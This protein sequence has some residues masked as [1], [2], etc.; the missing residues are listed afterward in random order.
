MK[1]SLELEQVNVKQINF[2]PSPS[3]DRATELDIDIYK[4]CVHY[5]ITQDLEIAPDF[6]YCKDFDCY[7]TEHLEQLNLLCNDI[8]H[9]LLDAADHL[10]PVQRR[11]TR[12]EPFWNELVQVT[13][14]IRLSLHYSLTGFHL[15]RWAQVSQINDNIKQPKFQTYL[16]YFHSPSFNKQAHTFILPNFLFYWHQNA[17]QVTQNLGNFQI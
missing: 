9:I 3:W 4:Q 14:S 6:L 12:C 1:C 7:C 8:S 2:K 17:T 15:T 11:K 13:Q 16:T 10:L 5:M